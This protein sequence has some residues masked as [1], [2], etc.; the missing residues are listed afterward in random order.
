MIPPRSPYSLIQEDYWP[1]RFKILVVCILLNCTTRR[2]VEKVAPRL[3]KQYPDAASMAAADPGQLRSV[4]ESLG[5][6]NRRSVKLIEMSKAYISGGWSHPGELPGVG[7]Y[8]SAAWDIFV[9]RSPPSRPPR[10]HA[11][12]LWWEWNHR[13][14]K[15]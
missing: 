11:L 15:A 1:D 2:A 12:T 13:H 7:D 9:L 6:G 8:A 4:I 3:F 5:F 10:D 14:S